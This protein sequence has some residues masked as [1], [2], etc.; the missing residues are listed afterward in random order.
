MKSLFFSEADMDSMVVDLKASHCGSCGRSGV[1]CGGRFDMAFSTALC[2][3]TF[4]ECVPS[5][6]LRIM[7]QGVPSPGEPDLG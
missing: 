7:V 3:T 4:F 5:A 1:G 6:G 2:R